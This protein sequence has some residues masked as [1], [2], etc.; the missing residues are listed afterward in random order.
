MTA[1]FVKSVRT[2]TIAIF[3]FRIQGCIPFVNV[4]FRSEEEVLW[5]RNPSLT[6]FWQIAPLDPPL[7]GVCRKAY[8]QVRDYEY[9][10]S[11]KFR[12]HPSSGS[13]GNAD[14]VFQYI[15][16]HE[17]TH[18]PFLHLNKYIKNSLKI[19]KHLNLLY[20]PCPT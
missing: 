15:Y 9:F 10:I 5:R 2:A 4:A 19:F 11:I 1:I 3:Q 8:K 18:P 12:K 16:M 17:C 7:G 20:K 6:Y 14:Y 13:V